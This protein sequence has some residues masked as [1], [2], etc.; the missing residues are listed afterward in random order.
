MADTQPQPRP[1]RA[2]TSLRVRFNETDMQGHVNFGHFLFYFDVGLMDYPQAIGYDYQRMLDEDFDMLYAE[3]K[4]QY[5]SRALWPETLD[6]YTWVGHLGNKSLRFDFEV[7]A[8]ADG[9][10]VA[11][12]HIV[13]V[14]VRRQSLACCRVPDTFRAAIRDFQGK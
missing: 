2:L 3:A 13:A 10:E 5:H 14:I 8:R 1:G 7:L 6:L 12:G 9:R 11:T 4:V